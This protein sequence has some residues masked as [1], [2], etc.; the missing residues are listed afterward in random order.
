MH[1]QRNARIHMFTEI[2]N[3][4]CNIEEANQQ[5]K[6]HP[7][8]TPHYLGAFQWSSELLWVDHGSQNLPC[9]E[10]THQVL[11][12]MANLWSLHVT[13]THRCSKIFVKSTNNCHGISCI[14]RPTSKAW[15]IM[16]EP[17]CINFAF[18]AKNS[19]SHS[20][21]LTFLKT[22]CTFCH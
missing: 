20:D 7:W 6:T 14:K 3:P 2:H 8:G 17:S 11:H 21:N 12:Q 18:F 5:Q 19:S 22:N 9:A 15:L 10:N 1:T 4:Q 13:H 16:T